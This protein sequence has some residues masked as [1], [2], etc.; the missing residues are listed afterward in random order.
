MKSTSNR[1]NNR[2]TPKVQPSIPPSPPS[3]EVEWEEPIDALIEL[4]GSEVAEAKKKN[5]EQDLELQYPAF[6]S[7]AEWN[8][9]GWMDSLRGI[10]PSEKVQLDIRRG[11]YFSG[12]MLGIGAIGLGFSLP[13]VP[14]GRIQFGSSTL[15]LS[16]FLAL[17][18]GSCFGSAA[19][20]YRLHRM[21][22]RLSKL[23]QEPT[24]FLWIHAAL[25]TLGIGLLLWTANEF[26]FVA[27]EGLRSPVAF[28][29]AVV[30]LCCSGL[31]VQ[32]HY[33]RLLFRAMIASA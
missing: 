32:F 20:A 6:V 8:R 22:A 29:R 12:L 18:G 14:I 15:I 33:V 2:S 1:T 19:I 31:A 9:H 13:G 3:Q 16:C 7:Q 24:Y 4:I 10:D 11:L 5:R 23:K 21:G 26:G 27:S 28:R 30:G 25:A 17:L